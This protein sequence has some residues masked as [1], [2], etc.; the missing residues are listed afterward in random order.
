MIKF[1]FLSAGKDHKSAGPAR[2]HGSSAQHRT[3]RQQFKEALESFKTSRIAERLSV[4]DVFLS[5]E[6]HVTLA[7]LAEMVGVRHPDL[8]DRSFLKETMDMFCQFGFAQRRT[9]ESR[10]VTYEH[11]HLGAH[12][13]H[14][15]CTRCGVIQE[16]VD[17][18][19]ELLQMAVA[20]QFQFHALQ[21]KMEI[22][23]L[24]NRCMMQRSPTL[25]L[26]M[27]AQGEKV[28]VVSLS[29]GR[30][31]QKRLNDMGLIPGVCLQVINNNPSG[32]I[33]V[34]LQEA[35]LALGA[36]IAQY[37]QVVHDCSHSED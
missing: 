36:G 26:V 5:T 20:K 18:Q 3:E 28:K 1:S 6:K 30:E 24:C 16:F 22:Y 12:H 2:G 13:D 9:F 21:H 33:I 23:G 37:V 19:L 27:A 29:G 4:L 15:I 8:V 7:E 34:A 35:R 11:H 10:E 17:P 14:F 25:P 31:A 32:P